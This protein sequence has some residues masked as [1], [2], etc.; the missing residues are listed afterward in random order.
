MLLT[1][2][3]SSHT[4]LADLPRS[5]KAGTGRRTWTADGATFS[6]VLSVKLMLSD[7]ECEDGNNQLIQEDVCG[8]LCD[9]DDVDLEGD[10]VDGRVI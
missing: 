5:P 7:V 1:C 4:S 2:H 9:S 6:A 10:D 3:S 8:R